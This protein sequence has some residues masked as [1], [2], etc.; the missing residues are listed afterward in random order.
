[1]FIRHR[2]VKSALVAA[3][4]AL[5]GAGTIAFA[6]QPPAVEAADAP[7]AVSAPAPDAVPSTGKAPLGLSQIESL[8]QKQ[9]IRVQ[10]MEV[11]DHVVEAEGRDAS[12]REVELIVDRRTGEILSRR[13][14]D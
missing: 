5:V 10:E 11:R 2:P 4:V 14:D 8:L 12:N 6:Q 9:G 7:P 1:M 13:F 3:T